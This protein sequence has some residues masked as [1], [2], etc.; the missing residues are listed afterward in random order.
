MVLVPKGAAIRLVLLAFLTTVLAVCGCSEK[1]GGTRYPNALPDTH[2]SSGPSETFPNYYQV[3]VFW[4]GTDA[5]G[6]IDHYEIA[7]LRDVRRGEP[8]DLDSLA[9]HSTATN[10]ST[11]LMPAD[12][13]CYGEPTGDD[14]HYAVSYWGL[15][16]RAVD[17]DRGIDDSPASVFFLATNEI[18]RVEIVAPPETP[19]EG[20]LCSVPY[21]EWLGKDA[22]G[23]DSK[24][25]YKY[26]IIPSA[27]RSGLW[28]DGLPPLDYEGAGG[29]NGAPEIGRWSEWVPADCTYVSGIDLSE[30]GQG[31]EGADSIGL[32]VTVRDEGEAVLPVELFTTYNEAANMRSFEVRRQGC[33]LRALI[34]SDRL[35]VIGSYA[36]SGRPDRPPVIFE[37]TGLYL[38]FFAEE[39]RD[40]GQ[41]AGSYRY[42]F[43]GPDDPMSGWPVWTPTEP[44]REIG[45]DPEWVVTW[46]AAGPRHVPGVG[47]HVFRVELQNQALDTTCAEVHF[48]VLEGPAGLESNVLLVDDN[49][50][51]WYEGSL[52]PEYEEDEFQMWSDIL[53]GYDWQEWD[54]GP[55]FEEAVP[56][57]L[58][59]TATTV[60]WSVDSGRELSPDLLD[61]CSKRGNHLHSYVETGGNLLLI[62]M[63]PVYCTMYWYDGT[64]DPGQRQDI[65]SI[66]FSPRDLY[67]P[68]PIHHFM[69]DV[70]GIRRMRLDHDPDPDCIAAIEPCE[71]YGEWSTVHAKGRDEVDGWPGYFEGAFLAVEFRPGDDVHPFYGISVLENPDEPD[72]AWTGVRDCGR[73][74]AVYVEGGGERGWAAYVALPAWWFGRD[75]IKVMVR[76]LL[77][78][79]EG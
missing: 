63:A 44:L 16:V 73:I 24:L 65:T 59:G 50:S 8:L 68:L 56:P 22:D 13:C 29:N 17:N 23:D 14:P 46:P 5:D 10:D 38:S 51:R 66:E 57:H 72:T 19:A 69:W 36:C 11:F 70:F 76:R 79:F 47:Q 15:L 55:D 43:D 74:A 7:V 64:P 28:G 6:D 2:I 31:S 58:L 41:L 3:Q 21:L 42:Y 53:Q 71:G 52:I 12:S 9:W 75:E 78:M 39:R 34:H 60:I 18:P 54:T 37:G 1:G 20:A 30:Y 61:L 77:E 40:L 33:A 27:M 25:A 32:Y 4:Y 35:G 48:D 67:E 62:G 45:S 49:R 26:L